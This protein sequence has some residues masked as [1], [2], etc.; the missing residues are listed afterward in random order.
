MIQEIIS[1]M[2][3][4]STIIIHRHERPDPDALGSQAGL[5][6]IIKA[7]WPDKKV[8][9]VG[10][11]EP[12]LSFISKMDDV[13]DSEYSNALVIVCD[14][15]NTGRISDERYKLG[16]FLIK[17]DHHPNEEP[18]G[19]ICW[20]DTSAS[21]TCEMIYELY[22]EGQ[23][24]GLNLSKQSANLLYAGIVGDTGRFRFPNTTKKTHLYTSKLLEYPLNHN[25]F[26]SKLYKKDEH[27]VRLEGYI[28]QHFELRESGLAVVT[29]KTDILR[30]YKVST[31]ETSALVNSISDV[32]GLKAWVFFVDDDVTGEIRVRLRSKGP[33]INKIAQKYRGGGH[34][35]AS[36]AKASTWEETKRVVED[37][38]KLCKEYK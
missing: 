35:L 3:E 19:D 37:L 10:E 25:E 4:Y 18:Y 32:T 7:T 30:K 11:E 29:L 31:N 28:L 21:S 5:A 8:F 16:A 38:D 2:E 23:T 6:E 36:G 20:V 27:L 26:Y 33:V 1:R 12:S 17:I 22:E 13:A 24:R 15:A 34:P 9:M 14:T